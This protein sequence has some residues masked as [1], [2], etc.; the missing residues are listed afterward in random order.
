MPSMPETVPAKDDSVLIVGAG[1]FG[2]STALHLARD[3]YTNITVLDRS[4]V[5]SPYSA[6]NDLNKIV[7]AEYEDPF[8]AELALVCTHFLL[9][10]LLCY[11]CRELLTELCIDR[12][13]SR[14]GRRLSGPTTTAP[15]A[16]FSRHPSMP[17]R[18]LATHS[19]HRSPRS[20]ITP[21]SPLGHSRL[22]TRLMISR[23]TCQCW[24]G[25]WKAGRDI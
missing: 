8:Y 2:L 24:R 22:S 9:S 17:P 25:R 3:G 7:R 13:Q 16:T 18:K 21:P 1:V 20:K 15:R 4:P 10:R 12:M 5:P 6:G 14:N 19:R 11:S 23:N